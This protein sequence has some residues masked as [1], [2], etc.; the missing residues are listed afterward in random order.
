MFRGGGRGGRGDL[1]RR[2]MAKSLSGAAATFM[3]P[4]VL[5]AL[6]PAPPIAPLHTAAEAQLR[7]E[8]R[9]EAER[10]RAEAGLPTPRLTGLSGLFGVFEKGAPPPRP[11]PPTKEERKA[12]RRSER[13]A[14]A[15]KVIEDGLAKWDPK[16]PEACKTSD[17]CAS[18]PGLTAGPCLWFCFSLRTRRYK[19]LFIARLAY[20]TS[21]WKLQRELEQVHPSRRPA[22][23]SLRRRM[24]PP[25]SPPISSLGP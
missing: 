14:A 24:R 1:N 22:R 8:L 5:G 19:T 15:Q 6:A 3:P 23:A 11:T 10:S 20:E 21:A 2:G 9:E 7:E 18:V 25:L 4:H 17:G 12:L 16:A 13:V